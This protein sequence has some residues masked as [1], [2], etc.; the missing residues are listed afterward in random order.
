MAAVAP[1]FQHH[2]TDSL[3][4]EDRFGFWADELGQKIGLSS[5]DSPQ[6]FDFE[7]SLTVVDTVPIS[8][9]RARQRCRP[10]PVAAQPLQGCGGL[11]A[12]VGAQAGRRGPL[13]RRAG[14]KRSFFQS[15]DLV[16]ND[17]RRAMRLNSGHATDS[18]L[19]GLAAPLVSRWLGPAEQIAAH[20]FDIQRG[21]GAMLA[22][23]LRT[24][25]V[26]HLA[27]VSDSHQQTLV[28]EH[29]LS[30]LSFAMEQE[31]LLKSREAVSPRDQELHR[32]MLAC[33]RER[34]A[35]TA[36]DASALAAQFNVSV[37]YVHKVFASA[38]RGS[39]FLGTLR[40]ERLQA[41]DRLL[42]TLGSSITVADIAWQCGF[43][44]PVN[45]G[46]VFRQRNGITPG[47]LAR[48]SDETSEMTQPN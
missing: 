26:E 14:P 10:L 22:G 42:R 5:Y 36:F 8:V 17:S 34:Y 44:D 48:K 13:V 35:D 6:R 7:Q 47:T 43:A 37:R 2:S 4:P 41:A 18:L 33:I 3:R 1:L 21:W 29:V 23:Y 12:A 11:L 9:M 20:K 27:A 46:R 38:G 15:G 32:R 45:F 28:A 24:L 31:G 39:T 19:I 25:Q 30:L 40:Q 16:V